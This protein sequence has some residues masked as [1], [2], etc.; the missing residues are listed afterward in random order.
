MCFVIIGKIFFDWRFFNILICEY[1]F[2]DLFLLL[3]YSRDIY[4]YV[5]GIGYSLFK[6][7]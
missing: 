4:F 3:G 2:V 5:F 1:D 7:I 6:G